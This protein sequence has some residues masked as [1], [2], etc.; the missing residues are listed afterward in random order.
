MVG[1][2][3]ADADDAVVALNEDEVSNDARGGDNVA[4]A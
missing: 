3:I 1:D 4:A 2:G